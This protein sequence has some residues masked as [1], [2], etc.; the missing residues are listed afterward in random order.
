MDT[1]KLFVASLLSPL[2]ISLIC[3]TLGWLIWLRRKS[4]YSTSFIL[5]GTFILLIGGLSGL[6]HERRRSLEYI[7][8]PLD[9]ATDLRPDK[10]V[11]A[12]VLGTGF[13]SDP[14]LP[15]NCQVSS[16]FHARLLEG[17]RIYRSHPQTRLLVSIAGDADAAKKQQFIEQMTQ[18]LQLDPSRVAIFTDA[19]S[20]SD[21]AEEVSK[22]H[23]G[24]QV[25][26]ITSASHMVRAFQIFEDE[27]LSPIAAPAEFWFKRA[28][29][30]DEKI[31]PRWIPSTD[32]INSNHQWLYE[33]I[34]SLWHAVSGD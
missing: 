26:V 4:R 12:V 13:N 7:H 8:P 2:L 27:D 1:F 23:K 18:L 31:W 10:P 30:P 21:E 16:T 19:K 20:T 3:Q 29:S 6:T 14:E 9:I 11:L 32:G 25:V 28:G 17:V 22:R 15:A 24:E 34:A 5:A 33:R